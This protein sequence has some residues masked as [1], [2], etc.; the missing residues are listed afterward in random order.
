MEEWTT[1]DAPSPLIRR[2]PPNN[3]EAERAVI[4]ACFSALGGFDSLEIPVEPGDFYN[5]WH[6][7][8]WESMTS[9]R[10]RRILVDVISL[11]NDLERRGLDMQGERLADMVALSEAVP[12]SANVNYYARI[13]QAMTRKRKVIEAGARIVELGFS[14]LRGQEIVDKAHEALIEATQDRVAQKIVDGSQLAREV[15]Q[16]LTNPNPDPGVVSGW[17][18]LDQVIQCF[19]P[20]E[21]SVLAARPSMGKSSLMLSLS[22]AMLARGER[23]GV[24]SLEMQRLQLACNAIGSRAGVDTTRIRRGVFGEVAPGQ[25]DDQVARDE[26]ARTLDGL[27]WLNEFGDRLAIFD[28]AV[29]SIRQIARVIERMVTR[30]QV[31][32]V[33]LDYMQLLDADDA[34][35]QLGRYAEITDVSKGLKRIARRLG[36]HVMALAQLNRKVEERR[37][38][39]PLMSDLRDSGQVEQDADVIMLLHRPEVYW[40]DKEDLKGVGILDVAK[41]RNG[42]TGVVRLNFEKAYTRFEPE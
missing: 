36:I 42:P 7:T 20:G 8:V 3:Q 25:F 28:G 29:T 17:F 13:L 23:V 35:R 10:D 39:R 12:T 4:G 33:A 26:R 14:T 5:A 19:R 15:Y 24:C 6:R 34:V 1:G 27:E 40:P 18:Q 21:M 30:N 2:T 38:K 22:A 9:L 11:R 16:H 37:D 31:R 41:N 32:F